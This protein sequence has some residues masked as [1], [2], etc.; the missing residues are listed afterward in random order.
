MEAEL[1]V[2]QGL[3]EKVKQLTPEHAAENLDRQE[4]FRPAGNPS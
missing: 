3:G 2:G 1:A 4:E